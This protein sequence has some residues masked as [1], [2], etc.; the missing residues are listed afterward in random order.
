MTTQTYGGVACKPLAP[1]LTDVR[2]DK[3]DG[4]Y[5]VV[6]VFGGLDRPDTRGYSCGTKRDLAVRLQT[7]ILEGAVCTNIEYKKDVD[8]NGYASYDFDIRMRCANADLRK[9]GY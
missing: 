7:A 8:G 1:K 9:L 5:V 6:P 4:R 3:E 2:I